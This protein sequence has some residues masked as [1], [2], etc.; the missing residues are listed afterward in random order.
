MPP[1]EIQESELWRAVK[2][3]FDAALDLP[4]DARERFIE[5]NTAGHPAVAGRLRSMLAA[6]QSSG[7]L[8]DRSVPDR[9]QSM[10]EK[11]EEIL[12][13]EPGTVIEGRYRLVRE[14]GRGGN[15]QVWEA[16][17]ES[18]F[19][20]A[21]AIKILR[22][23]ALGRGFDT[24]LKALAL[25]DHTSIAIP[26][27]SGFLEDGRRFL[28]IEYVNGP[29]L[30]D[31]LA[32]GPL[33]PMRA[34]QILAQIANALDSAHRRGVW[35][36]D[37]K[38]ENVMLRDADEGAEQAVLVD[39]GIS[40]LVGATSDSSSPPAGSLAYS[41][42]EQ[43]RGTPCAASD[44][45]SLARMAVEMFTGHKPR[46][47]EPADAL[48]ARCRALRRSVIATFR[49]ALS[50]L[51]D[52]RYASAAQFV[53]EL[54]AGLDPDRFARRRHRLL[55]AAFCFT[56]FGAIALH[57]FLNRE[58]EEAMIQRELEST[59]A[60]LAVLSSLVEAGRLEPR[61]LTQSAQGAIQRLKNIVNSGSKD[62]KVLRALFDAQ[63]RFGSMHGH[64]GIPHLGSV[65][66]GIQ[67][68]EGALKT[69]ESLYD[70][71][72][73]DASYA[74]LYFDARES[75]AA[76]LIEA[77]QYDRAKEICDDS[78]TLIRRLESEGWR[79]E[80]ADAHRANMLMTLSRVYLHRAEWEQCAALRSEGVRLKRL[81]AGAHK[82]AP[83]QKDLAS[84]LATRGFAY[85]EMGRLQEALADYQESEAIVG[86]QMEGG[87]GNLVLEWL[88]AKNKLEI[89]KIRLLSGALQEAESTLW[90]AVASHRA[91][92][93]SAP[94]A[95]SFQRTFALSLSWLAMA[96]YRLNRPPGTWRATHM[97]ASR[98]A[99]NALL[100][101]PA[102]A[103][104]RDEA[105][106]I[107][108]HARDC[109]VAVPSIPGLPAPTS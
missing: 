34:C 66:A 19:G 36:L 37:L 23:G 41:A 61:M 7:S 4:A 31:L 94:Q 70:D 52:A 30:R 80:R 74:E 92:L 11:D 40:R 50:A 15:G 55:G 102:N 96:R 81:A 64:P 2:P 10:P 29:S 84:A 97:E 8:L 72:E 77:G 99:A 28:V 45:Y 58:R 24:E 65:D 108:R 106:L 56:L 6:H 71:R 5:A 1:G 49:R 82:E 78:L 13:E 91:L 62:P 9:I 63:M 14:L 103:K 42:P 35:H 59:S 76:N 88:A 73:K 21:V 85:R 22:A 101:D 75:L 104:A 33:E 26:K 46:P 12:P 79:A 39:F 60:Q 17:D 20:R 98:V 44:Q 95:V 83:Y 109:G 53:S 18:V 51:P 48:L 47:V 32:Q 69:L 3:L 38:P 86:R 107:R 67:S 27:D 93:E 25:L 16:R 89:G 68:F 105:A 87:A 57:L 90:S 43:L 100:N 54:E